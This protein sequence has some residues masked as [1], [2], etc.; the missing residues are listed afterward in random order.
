VIH[1]ARQLAL[2][3]GAAALSS[4]RRVEFMSLI[5]HRASRPGLFTD[6]KYDDLEH[7]LENNPV[8]AHED[9]SAE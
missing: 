9:E 6:L 1:Q 7:E 8:D 5:V 2:D 4:A 3:D